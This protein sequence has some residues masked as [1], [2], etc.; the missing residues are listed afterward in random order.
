ME[1]KKKL[2]DERCATDNPGKKNYKG[3]RSCITRSKKGKN[4]TKAIFNRWTWKEFEKI[5]LKSVGNK[6][7]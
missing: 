3:E 2:R 7:R 4:K 1:K 6:E 5:P